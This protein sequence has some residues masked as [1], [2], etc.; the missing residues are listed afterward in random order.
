MVG[1][2]RGRYIKR[3]HFQE[4]RTTFVF[5]SRDMVWFVQ[6]WARATSVPASDWILFM[7]VQLWRARL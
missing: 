3:I 4:L 2:L 7:R 1:V 6:L 5:V